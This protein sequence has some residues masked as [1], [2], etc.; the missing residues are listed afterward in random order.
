MSA[1]ESSEQK[2][3]I[4][5]IRR[6]HGAVSNGDR[7]VRLAASVSGPRPPIEVP[8]EATRDQIRTTDP[9]RPLLDQARLAP[10]RAVACERAERMLFEGHT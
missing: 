9:V 2:C 7:V 3:E 10:N 1:L 4:W 6:S 5:R 8:N